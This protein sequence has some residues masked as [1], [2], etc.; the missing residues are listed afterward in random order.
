M[1]R[2]KHAKSHNQ[3]RISTSVKQDEH[4]PS[5]WKQPLIGYLFSVP[6]VSLVIGILGLLGPPTKFT[7]LSLISEQ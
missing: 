7:T 3:P 2:Q 1:L 5:F 6:L 4:H